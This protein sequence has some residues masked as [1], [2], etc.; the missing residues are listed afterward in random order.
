LDIFK[1]QQDL[2]S[3]VALPDI[4][5]YLGGSKRLD[6]RVYENDEAHTTPTDISMGHELGHVWNLLNRTPSLA[7]FT[8]NPNVKQYGDMSFSELHGMYWENV[9]RANA[10]LPLRLYYDFDNVQREAIYK[11]NVEFGKP[12]LAGGQMVDGIIQP[13]T[14]VRTITIS[15][16]NGT[17]RTQFIRPL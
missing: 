5:V 4:N 16:L 17:P 14:V 15:G 2:Q 1:Y 3:G 10:N 7:D 9:L 8:A 6:S 13:R 11:A 12:F